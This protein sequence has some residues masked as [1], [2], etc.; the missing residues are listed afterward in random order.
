MKPEMKPRRPLFN[1]GAINQLEVSDNRSLTCVECERSFTFSRGE[2]A[3]YRDRG[4]SDPK[5]CP[6][7]RL[8]KKTPVEA[9]TETRDVSARSGISVEVVCSE[10][11]CETTVPFHPAKNR[12]V[13]CR[14]CFLER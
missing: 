1:E 13:Y 10:C 2:Q 14:S 12:P 5:R 11:G 4:F 3:F 7:C 9:A 8:V 6:T